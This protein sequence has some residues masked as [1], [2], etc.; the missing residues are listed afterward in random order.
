MKKGKEVGYDLDTT[1]TGRSN[2]ALSGAPLFPFN[3]DDV[4]TAKALADA[5]LKSNGKN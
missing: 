5:E 4:G 1:F 2:S 3:A